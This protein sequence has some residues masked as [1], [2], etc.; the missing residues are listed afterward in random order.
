[1]TFDEW[2]E[3]FLS[4]GP[5]VGEAMTSAT[6]LDEEGREVQ[7]AN[8][9][10]GRP[11][12]L[13]SASLTCPIARTRIPKLTALLERHGDQLGRG[14]LYCKEAH[15]KIDPAPHAGKEW[16]TADNEREGILHRQPTKVSERLELAVLM[17]RGWTPEYHYFV[18]GMDDALYEGFGTASCMGILIDQKGIVRAKQGWL[19]PEELAASAEDLLEND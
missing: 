4:H 8:L 7:L 3:H 14:V 11:A 2:G 10:D 9:W 12:V 15:P 18:D 6:L 17:R 13:V 19:L 16:I 1:M 5:S